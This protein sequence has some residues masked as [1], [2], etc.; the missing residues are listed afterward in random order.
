MGQAH[1]FAEELVRLPQ[2]LRT[3]SKAW[4][5]P[6]LSTMIRSQA[7]SVDSRWAM[8]NI[9]E[10]PLRPSSVSCTSDSDFMSSALVGSSRISTSGSIGQRPGQ[11]DAL[12]LPTAHRAAPLADLGV[13]AL[14]PADDVV[15][16][17]GQPG[18][19]LDGVV[20]QVVAEEADVV[21]H[22]APEQPGLLGHERHAPVP[23][24]EADVGRRRHR[25]S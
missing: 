11:H 9:V 22:R 2:S 25:R 21:G 24:V 15:V 3:P 14:G 13:V 6:S 10:V 16:Q 4:I 23:R 17:L 5:S 7:F 20:G 18:G 12:P 19:L 8:M 1:R